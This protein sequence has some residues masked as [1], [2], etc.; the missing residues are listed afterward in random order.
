MKKGKKRILRI[1]WA[2]RVAYILEKDM[3]FGF[4]V[5]DLLYVIWRTFGWFSTYIA[6]VGHESHDVLPYRVADYED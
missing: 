1:I 4:E 3:S 6:L 5:F 2:R